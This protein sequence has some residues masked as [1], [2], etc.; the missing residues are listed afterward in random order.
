MQA[1]DTQCWPAMQDTPHA[2][3]L[4]SS[5]VTL[6]SQPLATLRSQSAKPALHE[7]MAQVPDAHVPVPLAGVHTHIAPA[8]VPDEHV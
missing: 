2:P 3:Q 8:Q 1:P 7:A 6:I 4:A 5:P